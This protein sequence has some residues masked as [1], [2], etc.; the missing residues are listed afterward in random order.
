MVR[1][2][3]GL[4]LTAGAATVMIPVAAHPDMPHVKSGSVVL[5]AAAYAL[6]AGALLLLAHYV[7]LRSTWKTRPV[8]GGEGLGAR[9]LV[10]CTLLLA[11][12]L[13]VAVAA[14][15]ASEDTA[16]IA[17]SIY[18]AIAGSAPKTVHPHLRTPCRPLVDLGCARSGPRNGQGVFR[19]PKRPKHP[20]P[21]AARPDV[22][23]TI[24]R[25]AFWFIPLAPILYFLWS[26]RRKQGGG[27]GLLSLVR[28]IWRRLRSRSARLRNVLEARLPGALV[29]LGA[30]AALARRRGGLRLSVREQI[31]QYYLN[32]VGYAQRHGIARR[33]TQTP[34]EF[35]H[36]LLQ[37]LET[38]HEAWA[39][40]TAD[41][42]EARYGLDP[43]PDGQPERAR[44]A[45]RA[46]RAGIR[47]ATRT[48][49][50]RK[51]S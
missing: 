29:D 43:P 11:S 28:E 33:P 42:I 19:H 40:L 12:L 9:W 16:G 48:R 34:E 41:F 2:L 45:W 4:V 51:Q 6:G 50:Q 1:T 13:L 14:P 49:P 26:R 32:T 22:V 24:A 8:V 38:G 35:E 36:T 17:G 15:I 18:A 31:V 39:T 5:S 23:G 46:T 20:Q 7:S 27:I 21:R 3:G 44:S 47:D 30:S 10:S 37:R 25:L